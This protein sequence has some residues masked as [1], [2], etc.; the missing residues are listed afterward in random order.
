MIEEGPG[1]WIGCMNMQAQL[2]FGN[3]DVHDPSSSVVYNCDKYLMLGRF[4]LSRFGSFLLVMG[5]GCVELRLV[6]VHGATKSSFG[7]CGVVA[8]CVCL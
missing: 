2:L 5:V 8:S 1:L 7:L 6:V 4:C 3:L